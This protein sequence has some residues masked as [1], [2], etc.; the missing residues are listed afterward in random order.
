MVLVTIVCG[1]SVSTGSLSDYVEETLSQTGLLHRAT[2]INSCMNNIGL[3]KLFSDSTLYRKVAIRQ[4]ILFLFFLLL[5]SA[6]KK[7]CN[8]F[9]LY[10]YLGL[11]K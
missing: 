2:T 5:L 10:I 1:W 6:V 11:K 7:G 9:L 8:I 4:G 3:M